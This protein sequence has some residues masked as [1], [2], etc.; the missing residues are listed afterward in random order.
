MRVKTFSGASVQDALRQAKNEMGPEAVILETRDLKT[1]G[2]LGIGARPYCEVVAGVELMPKPAQPAVSPGKVAVEAIAMHQLKALQEEVRQM[3]QIVNQPKNEQ[4]ECVTDVIAL[5]KLFAGRVAPHPNGNAV[6]ALIGPT[7]VGKTTT[8]AKLAAKFALEEQKRVGLITLDTY[9]IGAVEQLRTYARI[10]GVPLEV[11]HTPEDLTA[12]IAR[13]ADK[14][15]VLIDTVG[16]CQK[17]KLQI[18]ELQVFLNVAKPSEVHLV[19]SASSSLD[20]QKD[21][22]RNFGVLAPN[23]LLFTK[24]DEAVGLNCLAE[25]AMSTRLPLSYVTNGQ[26]VP[27]D[28]QTVNPDRLAEMVVGAA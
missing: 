22:V 18:S 2:F 8:L 27:D 17:N 7:G 21:V 15:I 26:N 19:I 11:A 20:V 9:R 3:K 23:R 13:M 1:K 28:I 5:R 6:I 25:V 10:L 16:R 4:P 12:A 14:D 24:L